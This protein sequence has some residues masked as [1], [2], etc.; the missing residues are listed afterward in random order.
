MAEEKKKITTVQCR[1]CRKEKRW[2]GPYSQSR[3]EISE[4]TR[5][6]N[7]C[8][9]IWEVGKKAMAATKADGKDVEARVYVEIPTDHRM[10]DPKGDAVVRGK[11]IMAAMGG[12]GLRGTVIGSRWHGGKKT[13]VIISEK[14]D[15]RDGGYVSGGGS[16]E[17]KVQKNRAEAM[18]RVVSAFYNAI[19]RARV[20]GF[21]EGRSLLAGLAKGELKLENFSQQVDNAR[22]GRKPRT[23]WDD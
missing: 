18:R 12:I 16:L 14:N 23:S 13:I 11:D 15:E 7:D 20:Y 6:C 8:T 17:F 21:N 22:L 10:G 19:A 3:N 1:L 9:A 2:E 5:V 4:W